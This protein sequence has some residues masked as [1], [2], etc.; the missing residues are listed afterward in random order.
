MKNEELSIGFIGAGRVGFTL[1]R[2]FY[3]NHLE[4][5]GYFSK[6]S[7][8]A[9]E[10]AVFTH[11]KSYQTIRELAADSQVIFITV[12]DSNIQEVYLQ[13]KDYDLKNKILCHC[14]GALSAEVFSDLEKKGAYG[15][16]VHPVLAINDKE[17]SYKEM[18]QAFFTVE[19]SEQKMP[20]IKELFRKLGNPVQVITA[21]N[22]YKYHASLVMASN[23]VIA[24]YH[25]SRQL[26]EECGFSNLAAGEVIAPLFL[27]NAQSICKNGCVNAL[28]GPVDRNDITTVKKH[29]SVLKEEDDP[30]II[31]VYRLLSGE[32]LKITKQ[33]YPDRNSE[34]L[35]NLLCNDRMEVN[36]E[37]YSINV[38]KS[39]KGEN[40]DFNADGI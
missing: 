25:I 22:K 2:Y 23:L 37:E 10:A 36:Y 4:L 39:Q 6:S 13:L 19:G 38:C 5:S 31:D 21:E 26:L 9:C 28:T 14:S 20:V 7:G 1:G 15:Y 27:G 29:L 40:K 16:S 33:K 24:L 35:S 11:S 8:H 17:N 18:R 12:P 30:A 32:L 34:E 3:E